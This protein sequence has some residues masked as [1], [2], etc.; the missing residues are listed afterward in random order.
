MKK[1]AAADSS[2]S[3]PAE[4]PQACPRAP[5]GTSRAIVPIYAALTTLYDTLRRYAT[6]SHN[7]PRCTAPCH[8][9]EAQLDAENSTIGEA[10]ASPETRAAMKELSQT[11]I[12][13]SMMK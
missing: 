8:L 4:D 1:Q 10:I 11:L 3:A 9:C 7:T 2:L 6:V 5:R 13:Y 12:V